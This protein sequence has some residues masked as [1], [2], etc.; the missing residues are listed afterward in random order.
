M[1]KAERIQLLNE[2]LNRTAFSDNTFDHQFIEELKVTYFLYIEALTTIGY[3]KIAE[4]RFVGEYLH[5][6]TS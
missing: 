4:L 1:P 3:R 2:I 6:Y 5:F